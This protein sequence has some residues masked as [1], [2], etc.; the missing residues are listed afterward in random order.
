ME[1]G[2]RQLVEVANIAAE[3]LVTPL[4]VLVLPLQIALSVQISTGCVIGSLS[5][6]VTSCFWASS[7]PL[8]VFPSPPGIAAA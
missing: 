2:K 1:E 3:I 7:F 4:F 6:E 8:R 5:I